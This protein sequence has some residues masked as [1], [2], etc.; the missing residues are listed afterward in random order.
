MWESAQVSALV[1]FFLNHHA[2]HM[3]VDTQLKL[4]TQI[5]YETLDVI[6]SVTSSSSILNSLQSE[7]NVS[8]NQKVRSF[9]HTDK[10]ILT[11]EAQTYGIYLERAFDRQT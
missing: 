5:I 2:N 11:F 3:E 9:I 4:D 1:I 7:G 8:L 6:N 10:F